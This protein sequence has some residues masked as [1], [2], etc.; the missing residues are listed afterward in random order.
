MTTT[1]SNNRAAHSITV[2][3]IQDN[4]DKAHRCFVSSKD[5]AS[6]AAA[7][8]YLVWDETMSP[9]ADADAKKWIDEKIEVRNKEF[10]EHNEKVVS[11]RE[12]AKAFK[13][14]TLNKYD[15][16]NSKPTNDTDRK[17]V[18]EERARLTGLAD[19]TD[20]DWMARRKILVKMQANSSPFTAI[21]KFGLNFDSPDHAS[22]TSRYA[23]VLE[24]VHAHFDGVAFQDASEIVTAIKGAGGFEAVLSLRRGNERDGTQEANLRKAGAE[25]AEIT[26]AAIIERAKDA[27]H[28]AP[29]INT[30]DLKL[31]NTNQDIIM[32]LGRYSDG[33]VEVVDHIPLDEGEVDSIIS[34]VSD[35][36]LPP[37]NESTEFIAHV[38]ALGDL[39]SE[40]KTTDIARDGTVSGP[41][42]VEQR[43]FSLIPD[44]ED[45]TEL[46]I[47]A[48]H[49][50][51]SV[52]IKG[53][54]EPG[55]VSLGKAHVALMMSWEAGR[56]LQDK[57][58]DRD[59]RRLIDIAATDDTAS[60][61]EHTPPNRMS[62][63]VS[64]S[65]LI[66]KKH[67]NGRRT[68]SWEDM[69]QH[70]YR[71]LDVDNFNPQ[72]TVSVPAEEMV[73]LYR[74]RLKKWSEIADSKKLGKL[75]TLSFRNDS[76]IYKVDGDEDFTMSCEDAVDVPVAL[77]FRPR[78]LHALLKKLSEQHARA[79][80]VSGDDG[81]LFC[82]SWTD[83]LGSYSVY[84]PTGTN[85]SRLE[86]RRIAPMRLLSK[87]LAS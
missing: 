42:L 12:R 15:L 87:K 65:A 37:T 23:T 17:A 70:E 20:I 21:V 50:S 5:S 14:G 83:H 59:S 52:V 57:L 71:P 6:E 31:G 44:R 43:M 25:E 55:R 39:V 75:M 1:I 35:D 85:D 24:W 40:G 49:A 48:L 22:L 86:T 41:K 46:V 69:A 81:G 84:L 18:D 33:K 28:T 16:A 82:V 54:P 78:D 74:E 8:L 72:F 11:D 26:K 2:D 56:V 64:N 34:R 9:H 32:L 13:E 10:E 38:L 47:S 7:H 68:F 58:G 62:W 77:R 66:A 61:D 27:V 36:L 79:F 80:R 53:R 63:T 19:L 29:A 30:F 3:Q 76:I 60:G 67:Q 51:S 4:I 73:K 45:N